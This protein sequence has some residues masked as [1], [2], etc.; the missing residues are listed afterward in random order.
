MPKKLTTET[1]ILNA[2][3]VHGDRYDYSATVYLNRHTHVTIK[4]PNHGAFNQKPIYHTLRGA[5]CPECAKMICPRDTF[6]DFVAKAQRRHGQ[7]Y[8]YDSIHYTNSTTKMTIRCPRHGEFSQ[9]PYMHVYGQGCPECGLKKNA[10]AKRKSTD[11]F[12]SEAKAIHGD[13]YD[14]SLVNYTTVRAQVEI[15]CPTHGSFT[16]RASDHVSK[17]AIC[18]KCSSNKLHS[19]KSIAWLETLSDTIQ[20][21]EC[22]GEYRIPGTRYVVD[23]FCA[24]TNTVYEFHGDYW[25]GNPKVHDPAA[26]NEVAK[27]TFGQLYE[28][29]MQ[30][31][32]VIKSLGYN[33]VTIWESEWELQKLTKVN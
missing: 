31:E 13:R 23:G 20:H 30:R 15:V 7:V 14:Y 28:E 4:C 27:K 2:K 10:D 5:G 26:I 19:A 16:Q 33:I 12:I 6:D 18:P 3:A 24:I 32:E 11:Q 21:A 8:L 22:G 25:H 1:F 9:L 29:T 17:K